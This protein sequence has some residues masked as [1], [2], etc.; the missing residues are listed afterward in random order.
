[1]MLKINLTPFPIL[2]TNRLIL[3]RISL[4]DTSDFFTIRSN[5]EVMSAID[6][7]PIESMAEIES[8]IN[9]IEQGINNNTG[10]AWAVC[11]KDDNRMIGHFGFHRID[12]INYRAEIGYALLPKFQNRGLGSEALQ[13]ILNI[14]FNQFNF[15]SIEADVNPANSPSIKLITKM[16]FIKEAH[17][18]ENYFFR[19]TFLDSAIYSLLKKD[20]LC[21]QSE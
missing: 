1:M 6:K 11:L 17:F 12:F 21:I 3:R 5:K 15:H 14:A 9:L 16:G 20:Y 7:N 4:D 18:R 19:N 2:Y 10:I 13:A 8:F